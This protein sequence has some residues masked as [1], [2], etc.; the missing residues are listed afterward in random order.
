MKIWRWNRAIHRD[1]GY[2]CFG[3]SIIYALSGVA[4]NHTKDWNPNYKIKRITTNIG[5]ID[6]ESLTR[7]QV[8]TK[9]LTRLAY[10]VEYKSTFYPAPD[11]LN[12]FLEGNTLEV[13]LKNGVVVEEKITQRPFLSK[14]NFLHLNVP[15]KFWTLFADLYALA[16]AVLAVSGLF[17]VKGK[18]G[19]K[20]RGAWLTGLGILLP[21]IFLIWYA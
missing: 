5:Q 19:I 4:V 17:M 13:D 20:G 21:I 6:T 7:D 10:P 9:I 14:L 16:L 12:I 15:K 3:L 18:K 1:L 2:L 8:V 11:Y